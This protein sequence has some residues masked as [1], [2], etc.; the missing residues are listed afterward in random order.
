M[1]CQLINRMIYLLFILL[2]ARFATLIAHS[3]DQSGKAEP[4]TSPMTL[5]GDANART[6]CNI[7]TSATCEPYSTASPAGVEEYSM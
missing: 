7:H 1:I 4:N 6:Q 5:E 3:R 2:V